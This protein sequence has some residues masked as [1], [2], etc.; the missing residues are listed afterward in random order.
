MQSPENLSVYWQNHLRVAFE[1]S[2]PQLYRPMLTASLAHVVMLAEQ[3]LLPAERAR[4]L[5]G[6]LRE[7]LAAEDDRF[8]FDGSVEDVYYLVEQRLAAAAGIEKSELDVQLARSRNDLDAGVFRM[9]LR[10]NVLDQARQACAAAEAAA[11]QADRCAE[12]L[13]TG[14]THRRPAQP[15]TLGH[16]LAGYAEALL[17]QADEL[18]SVYDELDVNPLGSCAFAGTDLPIEPARLGE[19][20]GFRENFTSSYE[21]VAGAEHLMRTAAVQARILATGARMA[22]TMLDWMTY[23]WIATPDA[24]CQGSSIMPQKKNPVVLEHMCSMAGAAAADLAA[25]MNNVGAAWYEDSNN[26]TTDVQEHLWRAGDRSVRFL[27]MMGGLIEELRPQDPP[28]PEQV[29]ATG[30]TT[31]AI[32][33]ALAGAGIPW[34]GA[35]SVVGSLV[36]QAPPAEWTSSVVTAAIA[37]AGL[38]EVDDSVVEAALAAGLKPELVLDRPQVGGPGAAAVR[39]TAE[40]ALDRARS[41]AGEFAARRAVLGEAAAKLDA[42][43]DGVLAGGRG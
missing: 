2:A 30:A 4:Q 13:I 24:Y 11:V 23:G 16:V 15:T 32:A 6:G 9:V 29:V 19:L 31:T 3:G 14:F 7:L 10:D 26:A 22:R 34:R 18:L 1:K 27:T 12:V 25:T 17:S 37:E 42:A 21:A 8:V 38:G 40:L 35:H 33:E 28:S 5:L 20:L 43:V 39:R 36:R 41:L